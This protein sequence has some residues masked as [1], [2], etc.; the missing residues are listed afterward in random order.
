MNERSKIMPESIKTDGIKPKEQGAFAFIKSLVIIIG[1]AFCIRA[2]IIEP[3]KIPSGSMMPTL[4]VGDF[5]LVWKLS[6]GFRLPLVQKSLFEF[7][8]P[9]RGDVVVFTRPDDPN[10]SEDE[11]ET[12][13][14]KRVIGIPGDSVEVRGTTAYVNGQALIEPYAQ[15]SSGGILEGNF[16]PTIV[17]PDSVLLLGDNRDH[18]KD[19]RFWDYPFLPIKNI[20]GRAFMIYWSWWA[21]NRMGTIIR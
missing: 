2:T 21:F 18:S 13:I 5:I 4:Q 7:A 15:W 8:P 3:F 16:G 12:N 11:T 17:P 19:S 20:K 10:T 1:A 6:Y 9:K 14:I